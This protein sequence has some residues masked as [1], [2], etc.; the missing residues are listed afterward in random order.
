MA[1]QKGQWC[2][3]EMVV[4]LRFGGGS[5]GWW[6]HRGA[7]VFMSGGGV[8]GGSG[9]PEGQLCVSGVVVGQRNGG[10]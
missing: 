7:V 3:R 10:G 6:R 8:S 5:G 1:G 4:M 2:V 9:N